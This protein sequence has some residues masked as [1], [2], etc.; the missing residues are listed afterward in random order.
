MTKKRNDEN[1]KKKMKVSIQVKRILLLLFSLGIMGLSASAFILYGPWSWVRERL[2]TTAM[3]TMSHQYLATIFFD[4]ATI[5]EVLE[6]N[7]VIEVDEDTNPDLIKIDTSN[8]G[9][10]Y[11]SKYEKEILE[12]DEGND[13]FKV[14]RINELT[15]K[16]YLVAIYQPEKV[17]IGVTSRLGTTGQS[18]RVIARNNNARV[19][20]N[21]S[22]FYDPYWNSNG[23]IP[24]GTVIKD[25]KIIWDYVD[26]K[27]GGGFVGFNEDNKLVLVRTDKYSALNKYHLRDAIEFGPFLIVNGKASFVDGDGGWGIAPR[28]A[29][30]QRAD[31]IVLF[32]V[33]DGRGH[34]GSVGCGMV[35]LTKI[36]QRYGAVNAANMDGGSSSGLIID[37]EVINHP[38]AGGDNG[39]RNLPTAWIVTE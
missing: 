6:N 23:A 39:L 8:T 32:L 20:I 13:L 37:D 31:G 7:R 35:E 22:G 16:G 2:I 25:S 19:A 18:V 36:M 14:I 5:N 34:G 10:K 38:T 4:D 17:K 27:V 12:R 1:K 15:Y 24:H 9:T 33:I 11:S 3:T 30:G 26:A 28:T 21:A 29:I